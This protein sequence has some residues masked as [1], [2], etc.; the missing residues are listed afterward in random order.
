MRWVERE[1]FFFSRIC[2]NNHTWKHLYRRMFVVRYELRNSAI[3]PA[4]HLSE[5]CSTLRW[6]L[7]CYHYNVAKRQQFLVTCKHRDS[8]VALKMWFQAVGFSP[9]YTA[10]AESFI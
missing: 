6:S 9:S 4:S 3:T 7:W 8:S 10:V 2:E 1:A 5:R